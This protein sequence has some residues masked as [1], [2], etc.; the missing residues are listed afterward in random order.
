MT[1]MVDYI[2]QLNRESIHLRDEWLEQLQFCHAGKAKATEN[3]QPPVVAWDPTSESSEDTDE[4]SQPNTSQTPRASAANWTIE[5]PSDGRQTVASIVID[6]GISGTDQSASSVATE[7]ITE[8]TKSIPS[9]ARQLAAV[10]A[11]QSPEPAIKLASIKQDLAGADTENSAEIQSGSRDQHEI[12]ASF[13]HRFQYSRIKRHR[14]IDS[15]VNIIVERYP[16][17]DPASIM[18]VG[19]NHEIDVDAITAKIAACMSLRELGSILLIDANLSRRSMSREFQLDHHLGVSEIVNRSESWRELVCKTELPRLSVLAAGNSQ[20]THRKL[21]HG[22]VNRL[23]SGCKREYQY[24]VISGGHVGDLFTDVSAGCVDAVYVLVDM[25][26]TD[27]SH[28]QGAINYLRQ[29][30]ARVVGCVTTQR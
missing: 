30:G 4:T 18:F 8:P 27:R 21:E 28:A 20:I 6:N 1:S 5:T 2:R 11:P 15:V 16:A 7:V 17:N 25:N 3:D 14:H 9:A 29:L 19:L 10:D 23:F 13:P 26:E 12:V 22:K 24:A